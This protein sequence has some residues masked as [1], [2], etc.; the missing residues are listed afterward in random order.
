MNLFEFRFQRGDLLL[1]DPPVDLEL[2]FAGPAQTDPAPRLPFEMGPHPLEPGERIFKLR[3][4][5]RQTRLVRSRAGRE[6]VQ[7]Q[8]GSV[9]HLHLERLFQIPRLPGRQVVVEQNDVRPVRFDQQGELLDFPFPD[10]GR[11]I[12]LVAPLDQPADRLDPRRLGQSGEFVERL[13]RKFRFRRVDAD[14]NRPFPFQTLDP[15]HLIDV[16]RGVESV[17]RPD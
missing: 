6:D 10:T 4:F 13:V 17:G 15:R 3:Q 8:L 11:E 7:D 14:Q 12:G 9:D 1:G 2:F 5:D 16:G